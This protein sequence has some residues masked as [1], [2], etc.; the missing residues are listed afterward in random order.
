V[1]TCIAD[2]WVPKAGRFAGPTAPRRARRRAHP[3]DG[4]L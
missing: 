2:S 1:M 3:V 4:A